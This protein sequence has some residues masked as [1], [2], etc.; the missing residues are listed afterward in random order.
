MQRDAEGGE[1]VPMD[2]WDGYPSARQRVLEAFGSG[3]VSN[4][5]VLTGDIHSSW[6]ADLKAD[7]DAPQS[8]VVGTELVGTSISSGGDGAETT[9][10]ARSVLSLN[11]HIRYYNG[12]RGY[13][14]VDV[15]PERLTAS[16]RVVPWVTQPGAPLQTRATFVVENGRPGAQAG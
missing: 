1:I 15:A 4:P 2:M 11:P 6:V 5:I 16:Y 13:V 7:F 3:R 12:R 14:R 10:N 8:R 9:V